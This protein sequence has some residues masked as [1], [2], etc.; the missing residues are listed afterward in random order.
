MPEAA[1]ELL[2]TTKQTLI[3]LFNNYKAQL[4]D[5]ERI[6]FECSHKQLHRTPQLYVTFK[7]HKTPLKTRPVVSCIGS[8]NEA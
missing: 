4:P 5:A 2:A 8:F 1:T 6:Y 7:V 3:Q